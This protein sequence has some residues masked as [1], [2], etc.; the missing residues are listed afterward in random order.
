MKITSGYRC[1]K[2]PVEAKKPEPGVHSQGIAADI[3]VRGSDAYDLVEI[4]LRFGF[5]GI[6]INQKGDSRFIHL[7]ISTDENRPTI[8]SY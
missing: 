8:W 1:A 3:G 7:D 2:H 4:A 5:T 6:G